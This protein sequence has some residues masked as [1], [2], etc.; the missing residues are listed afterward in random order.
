MKCLKKTLLAVLEGWPWNLH[1]RTAKIVARDAT[2]GR[3]GYPKYVKE[4]SLVLRTANS[5]CLIE[6]VLQT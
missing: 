5:T 1:G 2:L 6:L 4:V 3:M